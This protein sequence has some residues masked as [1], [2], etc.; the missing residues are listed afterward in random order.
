MAAR[1]VK[2]Q[3]DLQQEGMQVS[4][5][6]HTTELNPKSISCFINIGTDILLGPV[7]IDGN[8]CS[9]GYGRFLS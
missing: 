9:T 7:R 5:I 6:Q 1:I 3:E 8:L 4:E 2:D